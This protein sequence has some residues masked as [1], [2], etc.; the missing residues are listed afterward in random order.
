MKVNNKELGGGGNPK[1][2]ILSKYWF[3]MNTIK[4]FDEGH[5]T[6]TLEIGLSI[7]SCEYKWCVR[8]VE[9]KS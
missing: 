6:E 9:I 5:S 4:T 8:V 3:Q 2:K 1:V 7:K